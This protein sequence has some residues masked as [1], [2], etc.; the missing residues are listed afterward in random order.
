MLLS[1][2][3]APRTAKATAQRVL[4][5]GLNQT[6][7]TH[8]K[9]KQTRTGL[10]GSV[11]AGLC[12]CVRVGSDPYIILESGRKPRGAFIIQEEVAEG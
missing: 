3:S 11:M 10:E 5:K 4:P 1:K 7:G 9:K 8:Q 2:R 6:V 12:G